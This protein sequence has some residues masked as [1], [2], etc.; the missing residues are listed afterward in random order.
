M[1]PN[2]PAGRTAGA[3][4]PSAEGSGRR[5]MVVGASRGIGAEIAHRLRR[6]GHEVVVTGRN[7]AELE[8]VARAVGGVAVVS[9]MTEPSG[10][11]A[12]I[13]SAQ[14]HQPD[15]VV[16]V[17][18]VR[19]RPETIVRVDPEHVGRTVGEHTR[20]LFDLARVLLPIQRSRRFGRW[21]LLSSSVSAQ[22]SPGQVGYVAQKCA[23]EGF[24]RTLAVEEGRFGITSNVVS[25]GF[26]PV[27]GQQDHY[28]EDAFRALSAMNAV[29]RPGTPEEVA[30]AVSFLVAPQA[31][32]VTGAVV[33]VTG[34]AELG[35]P[36]ERMVRNP[37]AAAAFVN[38]HDGGRG[39]SPG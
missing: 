28:Q 35:W 3:S 8:S 15:V 11:E 37:Q 9:D 16:G 2:P 7:A 13:K 39:G 26:V 5:A 1:G 24:S 17:A 38:E 19:E 34:G 36:I 4:S 12:L 14:R 25:A 10:I 21:V 33:P 20:Y 22:G 27:E 6:D 23:L 32:F 30:H 31:G 29:G 18:R